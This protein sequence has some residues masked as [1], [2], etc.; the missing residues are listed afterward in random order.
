MTLEEK[1][2]EKVRALLIADTT[3]DGYVNTRVYASHISS[4]SE[5]VYPA[6][7]LHLLSSAVRFSSVEVVDLELQIDAWLP[8]EDYDGSDV[9]A[10][11]ERI[12]VL[13]HRQSIRDTTIGL[14]SA[15]VIEIL[16]GPM[17]HE[18]DTNLFHYPT[19]YRITVM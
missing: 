13:L 1:T 9:L 12:R 15:N 11:H 10:V 5:P 3:L 8:A 7:S 18:D 4:I 2:I 17:M 6:I 16:N 14:N 19:R